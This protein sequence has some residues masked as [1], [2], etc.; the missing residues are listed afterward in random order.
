MKNREKHRRKVTSRAKR[1]LRKIELEAD[2]ILANHPI[3]SAKEQTYASRNKTLRLLGFANYDQ[4]L[5]SS[6]WDAIK[7]STL[8]RNPKCQCKGCDKEAEV[9]HHLGYG[10]ET[11]LGNKLSALVSLCRKHHY[12]IEHDKNGN[13]RTL[14]GAAARSMQLICRVRKPK[15]KCKGCGCKPRKGYRYCRAC[16]KKMKRE[17]ATNYVQYE[18]ERSK[19]HEELTKIDLSKVPDRTPRLELREH[20]ETLAEVLRKKFNDVQSTVSPI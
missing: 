20:K 19:R 9:V 3:P 16:V 14:N 11:L 7:E 15:I 17:F 10:R 13:K 12:I 6:L 18:Q 5:N 2:R 1:L 4:Y 8:R